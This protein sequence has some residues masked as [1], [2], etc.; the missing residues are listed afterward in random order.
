MLRRITAIPAPQFK[1]GWHFV[2]RFLHFCC[3]WRRNRAARGGFARSGALGQPGAGHGLA[4]GVLYGFIQKARDNP[5]SPWGGG[6]GLKQGA[7]GN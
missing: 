1:R 4:G 7:C 6:E 2:E 5:S 3:L